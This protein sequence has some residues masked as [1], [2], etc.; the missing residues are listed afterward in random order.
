MLI[1]FIYV[2]FAWR[3]GKFGGLD[4]SS[5]HVFV[6]PVIVQSVRFDQYVLQ[7]T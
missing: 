4:C 5:V 2:A 7:I 1:L 6:S 3:D